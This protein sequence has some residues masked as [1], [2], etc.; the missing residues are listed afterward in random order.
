MKDTIRLDLEGYDQA[1]IMETLDGFYETLPKYG[2]EL[3]EIRM[4][5]CMSER[6]PLDIG[7]AGATVNGVRVKIVDTG[8]DGTIEVVSIPKK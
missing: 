1:Y 2:R 5:A 6:L 3:V 4:R 8:F 7:D